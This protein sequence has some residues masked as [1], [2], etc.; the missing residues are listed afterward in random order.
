MKDKTNIR[1]LIIEDN[2]GDLELIREYLE[3]QFLAPVISASKSFK[4]ALK[5]MDANDN[6][7]DVI[8]LDLTLPDKSGEELI[9]EITLHCPNCPVVVLSGFADIEFSIR[10][11]SLGI[12]DYLVK[13]DISSAMLYKS[14]LYNIERKKTNLRLAES[15]KRFSNLFNLSPQPMWVYDPSTFRFVLVNQAATDEYGYTEEEFLSKTIFDIRPPGEEARLKDHMEGMD[16][17]SHKGFTGIF[18]HRKKNGEDITVEIFAGQLI[19]N[20]KKFRSVIAID[21]TQ[22]ILVENQITKAIIK[23]QDDERYEIG[24]ELH[25]NICQILAT[26]QLTLGMIKDMV[27]EKGMVYYD[28]AKQFILLASNEIRNLSHRLAPAFFTD[29]SLEDS[30][31]MLLKDFNVENRYKITLYFN[32]DVKDHDLSQGIKLNLYRILQEQLRNIYKYAEATEI[33]IDVLIHQGNLKMWVSDNGKGFDVKTKTDGIGLAN[34]RRRTELFSGRFEIDSS[35]GNGCEI[36]VYL[37]L[38]NAE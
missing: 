16:H 15:E 33:E 9:K 31:K 18:R 24:G 37:P 14:I 7:F 34:V 20:D 17:D 21:I 35:P 5:I 6:C 25:D 30:F 12:S 28:Q 13:D 36:A 3:E 1:V 11:L 26:C 38:E 29:S 23:T 27:P 19:V 8:L 22:K 2:A 32:Q 10:S 4:E